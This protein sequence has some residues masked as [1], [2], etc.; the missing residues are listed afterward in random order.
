MRKNIGD[1]NWTREI[2]SAF[3]LCGVGNG[4]FD[5]AMFVG[6]ADDF[7]HSRQCRDFLRRA[8][9]ITSGDHDPAFGILAMNAAN[10]SA[11]IAVGGGGHGARVQDDDFRLRDFF[12]TL[13]PAVA[14]LVFQRGAICLGGPA[15]EILY[16][17]RRHLSLAY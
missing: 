6:V 12:G 3:A 16:V 10:G 11:G 5:Q 14:E 9:R 2:V 1:K 17:K 13:K 4:N 8:L 15:A 7:G